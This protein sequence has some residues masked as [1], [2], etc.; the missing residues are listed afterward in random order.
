MTLICFTRFATT[1][2]WNII[3]KHV[4]NSI[5]C[6]QTQNT[7][8]HFTYICT[9]ESF[10]AHAHAI[11]LSVLC[12]PTCVEVMLQ[13]IVSQY[14]KVSSPFWDLWPDITFC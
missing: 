9:L 11:S 1:A 2:C 4:F 7:W 14:A 8:V 3:I 10:H 12:T 13:L 5:A 6:T